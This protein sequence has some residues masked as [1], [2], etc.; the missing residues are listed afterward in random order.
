MFVYK[1][2]LRTFATSMIKLMIPGGF[3]TDKSVESIVKI[4]F[5]ALV[6]NISHV[7]LLLSI[8]KVRK[9]YST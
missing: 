1:N 9:T 4:T 2:S 8:L 7:G 6:T 3:V 5:H